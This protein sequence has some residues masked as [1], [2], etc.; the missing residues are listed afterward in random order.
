MLTMWNVSHRMWV[1]TGVC[2]QP[3][4]SKI[5]IY[6]NGGYKLVKWKN[7]SKKVVFCKKNRWV[8]DSSSW[9]FSVGLF[10]CGWWF[11]DL[12]Q[13]NL[14][15]YKT[16]NHRDAGWCYRCWLLTSISVVDS[17]VNMQTCHCRHIHPHC[18]MA[19]S[20]RKKIVWLSTKDLCSELSVL[21][22]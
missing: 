15:N 8:T 14:W 9:S 2:L 16:V 1:K 22:N 10:V 18:H 5:M 7:R 4:D 19:S 17:S 20:R 21:V 6:L 11:C 12:W 13:S 3:S